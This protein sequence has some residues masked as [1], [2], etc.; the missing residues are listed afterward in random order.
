MHCKQDSA[1]VWFQGCVN[2]PLRTEAGPRNLGI[3]I[4]PNPVYAYTFSEEEREY[5]KLV[6]LHHIFLFRSS[7]NG[8]LPPLYLFRLR[9]K[10]SDELFHRRATEQK[11]R[12]AAAASHL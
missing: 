9:E 4:L 10:F 3:E 8:E 7:G 2:S 6:S 1:K 11:E 5:V 12:A